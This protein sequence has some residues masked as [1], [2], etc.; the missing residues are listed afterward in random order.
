[1]ATGSRARIFPEVDNDGSL[2]PAYANQNIINKR[3]T[4]QPPCVLGLGIVATRVSVVM[5]MERRGI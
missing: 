3:G 2:I 4:S 5:T 1:M